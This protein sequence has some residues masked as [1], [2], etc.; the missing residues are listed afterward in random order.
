MEPI[1]LKKNQEVESVR[2]DPADNSGCV[3]TY[4]LYTPSMKYSDSDYKT[5]TEVYTDEEFETKVIP[6]INQLYR[7]QY[8]AKKN[9][10]NSN[11][12]TKGIAKY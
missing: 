5:I 11:P 8:T 7:A 12:S 9:K 1:E 6:R 10:T 3:L 4:C 2:L